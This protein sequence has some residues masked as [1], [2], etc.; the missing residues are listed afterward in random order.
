MESAQVENRGEDTFQAEK[1]Q[2]NAHR[3]WVHEGL[4]KQRRKG[5]QAISLVRGYVGII[6]NVLSSAPMLLSLS[7]EGILTNKSSHVKQEVH[8]VK[9]E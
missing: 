5:G 6:C 8:L 1:D 9:Q 4:G 2:M 7:S 3:Y